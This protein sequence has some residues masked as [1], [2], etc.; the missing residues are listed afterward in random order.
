MV[1]Y[2]Q[3]ITMDPGTRCAGFAFGEDAP[4]SLSCNPA[5][6]AL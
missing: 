3:V 4:S 6:T 2:K 5:Q 1:D